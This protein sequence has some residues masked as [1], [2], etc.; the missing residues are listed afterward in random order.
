MNN[1]TQIPSGEPAALGEFRGFEVYPMPFFVTLAV[2]DVVAVANWYQRALGFQAMFTMPAPQ[3][4]QP[5]LIHLRRR[6]YQDVLL[7][8][9]S[10]TQAQSSS[11]LTLSF[12]AEGEVDALAEQAKAAEVLGRSRVEGVFDTPWNTHDLRVTDPVGNV[13]VFTGRSLNPDPKKH[14]AWREIFEKA[15]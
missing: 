7:R 1:N 4:G 6:K 2:E 15:K 9:T 13:L 3:G 14:E 10:G 11:T 12:S 5:N 8:P